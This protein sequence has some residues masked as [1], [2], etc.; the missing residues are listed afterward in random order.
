MP[1]YVR[2]CSTGSPIRLT[3]S[4]PVRSHIAFAEPCGK[5]AKSD[6]WRRRRS[7]LLPLRPTGYAPAERNSILL[8]LQRPSSQQVFGD[9]HLSPDLVRWP[10]SV[11]RFLL[12]STCPLSS[13]NALQAF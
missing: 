13:R 4:K 10:Q 3:L 12:S 11:S 6:P 8:N 1:G 5:N 2:P 7:I 9:D